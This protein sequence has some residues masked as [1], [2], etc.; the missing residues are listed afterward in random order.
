VLSQLSYPP[1][2]DKVG[3]WF[4]PVNSDRPTTWELKRISSSKLRTGAPAAPLID[5]HKR[6]IS[7]IV[8]D[9]LPR[10]DRPL[11][12]KPLAWPR[13]RVSIWMVRNTATA[14]GQLSVWRARGPWANTAHASS[15]VLCQSE[16][17]HPLPFRL[18]ATGG[19]RRLRLSGLMELETA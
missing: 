5:E 18:T 8:D 11:H 9:G 4:T 13:T 1:V 12:G 10:A 17:G 7:I 3:I 6:C 14:A 2:S 19:G 16:S 15:A